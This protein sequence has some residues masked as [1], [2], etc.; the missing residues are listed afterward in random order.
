MLVNPKIPM[1]NL[2]ADVVAISPDTAVPFI[3]VAVALIFGLAGGFF[4]GLL[5]LR[6]WK[7]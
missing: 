4:I 1:H 6:R 3:P 2:L 5:I 7:K